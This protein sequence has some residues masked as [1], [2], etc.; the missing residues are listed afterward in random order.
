MNTEV[1]THEV[2]SSDNEYRQRL[3]A[4]IV[5]YGETRDYQHKLHSILAEAPLTDVGNA[6]RMY[7]R[8]APSVRWV[9]DWG[10]WLVWNGLHWAKDEYGYL[11]MKAKE[12]TGYILEE[13]NT[14]PFDDDHKDE[15]IRRFT[16][17]KGS[18]SRGKLEAAIELL[19]SE[20]GIGVMSSLLNA[21]AYLLNFR[22]GTLD[23]KTLDF[24]PPNKADLITKKTAVD[25]DPDA[26]CPQWEAFMNKVTLDRADLSVYIQAIAGSGLVGEIMDEALAIYHGAGGNGKT[27]HIETIKSVIGDY[28]TTATSDLLVE[29]S[30]DTVPADVARLVGARALYCSETKEG[31]FLD[32][33]LVKG[34]T[35][36]DTRVAREFYGKFFEFVPVFTPILLTNYPPV[37]KGTDSGIWRRLRL[38]PWDY[39]FMI[40]PHIEDKATVLARLR[41][42]GSGIMNWLII[43]LHIRLAAGSLDKMMPEVVR[44]ATQIYREDSDILGQFISESLYPEIGAQMTKDEVYQSYK[45]Y[46]VENGGNPYMKK[47]L[48]TK[49]ALRGWKEHRGAGGVRSWL[50]Y[51]LRRPEDEDVLEVS[52]SQS[53]NEDN[54][55]GEL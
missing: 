29:K 39:N 2:T 37:I 51:R 14:I 35:G 18:Q 12:M 34:L 30:N 16:H 43:G 22:N 15:R 41:S 46:T 45:A 19:K 44:K 31:R 17:Q 23:L 48:G 11:I 6:L 28:A 5:E 33:A 50:G 32:E 53:E 52:P 3:A 24:R 10:T 38:I 47:T 55:E 49:L 13:I 9:A 8:Y 27:V 7:A 4:F 21:D 54:E 42:E 20:P 25:Y 36:G 1:T 40:D 26:Q